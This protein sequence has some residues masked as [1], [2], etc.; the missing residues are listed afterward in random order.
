MSDMQL[1]SGCTCYTRSGAIVEYSELEKLRKK[2]TRERK[3]QQI[4][5]ASRGKKK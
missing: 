2:R 4:K 1:L 3:R 5:R